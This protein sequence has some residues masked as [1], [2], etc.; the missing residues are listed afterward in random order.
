MSDLTEMMGMM[1]GAG[2]AALKA[3]NENFAA[4]RQA[5]AEKMQMQERQDLKALFA[6]QAKPSVSSI[7]AIDPGFAKDYTKLQYDMYK[8]QADIEHKQAQT[9]DIQQKEDVIK[10][11]EMANG[12]KPFIERYEQ[13]IASGI[14]EAQAGAE[15]QAGVG[16]LVANQAQA[17]RLPTNFKID[18]SHT[19]QSAVSGM[20]AIGVK[21]LSQERS[22]EQSRSE[23]RQ[24]G[25]VAGGVPM[26]AEQAHGGVYTDPLTGLS[27]G[28]P[29][30]AQ[31]SNGNVPMAAP[32]VQAEIAKN[33]AV[34]NNPNASE[35]DRGLANSNIAFL[36]KN[37][38]PTGFVTPAEMQEARVEQA[39]QIEAAK[40]TSKLET[41]QRQT[42]KNSLTAY[43]ELPDIS[44]LRDLVKGSIGSDIGYWTN[45]LGGVVGK[46]LAAGDVQSALSV[47]AAT[48]AN[49]VAFAPGSQSDKELQAR[50][51]QVGDLNSK[52]TVDQKLS[53][54]EEWFDKE[55]RHISKHGDYTD[56]ELIDLGK[57]GKITHETAMKVRARRNKGK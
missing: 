52:M 10:R 49:T 19:P 42:V 2:P 39:G 24:Q 34:A 20:N 48:M 18:P 33:M 13:Q 50:L 7:G 43:E 44:H 5:Q 32:D 14:P 8:D 37:A 16:S 9:S 23:S 28:T 57:E 36:T 3:G 15:Y 53:A 1:Y 29:S 25:L 4:A 46:S 12:L 27:T 26:N 55:Q 31:A 17:G 56:A 6:S 35:Y 11:Q 41:A 40:E 54:L 22:E 45:R 51:Q 30:I 21:T 38:A 47:V